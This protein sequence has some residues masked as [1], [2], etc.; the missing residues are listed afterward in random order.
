[1]V[2]L[3][4]TVPGPYLPRVEEVL[5]RVAEDKGPSDTI[6]ATS[7]ESRQKAVKAWTKWLED[8]QAKID[9]SGLND[10]ESYLGLI[11]VCEYDNQ[12]NQINGQVWEGSRGGPKRW[13]F[14][15][16]QGAMDAHSLPNGRI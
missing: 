14:S 7:G 11:T 8:N 12:V 2:S 1:F 4:Q 5:F 6:V 15:G 9:L 13:T 10:R 16:V 3:V